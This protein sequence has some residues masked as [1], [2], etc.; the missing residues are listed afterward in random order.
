[1][2]V[3]V[4]ASVCALLA[5]SNANATLVEWNTAGN[6]G[7]ETTEPSVITDVNIV[8]PINLTL[9]AGV[10]AAANGN[11]FG[12]S[13]WFDAGDAQPPTLANSIAGNDYIEFIVAPAMGF[14]FTP[15]S[16]AF[17]WDRSN[18]GP[19]SVTLRSSAD[20]FATD[21]GSISNMASMSANSITITGLTN[22]S[23]ATT[24]RLYGYDVGSGT[25]GTSGTA[26]FDTAPSSTVSNVVLDGFTA[27]VPEASSL[28]FGGLI[29]AV[30]SLKFGGRKLWPRKS[31]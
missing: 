21:I 14:V 23:S 8:G 28:L 20:S 26:G 3:V 13:N 27:A 25:A 29:A 2:F 6:T 18:T 9:G 16:F 24:F 30:A 5:A 10:T 4:T 1:M 7:T 11:R 19:D 17:T 12:G 22:L 15:T 31:A